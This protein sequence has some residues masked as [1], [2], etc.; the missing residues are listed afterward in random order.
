MYREGMIL[1]QYAWQEKKEADLSCQYEFRVRRPVE[2][3]FQVETDIADDS[4]GDV[5]APLR[6]DTPE[7]EPTVGEQLS[8]TQWKQLEKIL[9][10]LAD[11]LQNKPGRTTLI[12]HHIDTGMCNVIG[13][14]VI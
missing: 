3:S 6:N 4:V 9:A 11:L 13:S 12:E 10:K 7:G 5:D 1:S 2:S 8:T 14:D